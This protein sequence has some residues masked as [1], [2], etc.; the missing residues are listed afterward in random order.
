MAAGIASQGH[1]GPGVLELEVVLDTCICHAHT[2][3][4]RH[5]RV[6]TILL[7]TSDVQRFRQVQCYQ[8]AIYCLYIIFILAGVGLG[9]LAHVA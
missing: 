2:F 6:Y 7:D 5:M 4:H 8:V 3:V 1:G 9:F